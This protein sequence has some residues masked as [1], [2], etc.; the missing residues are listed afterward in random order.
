MVKIYLENKTMCCNSCRIVCS[1]T[2][3]NRCMLVELRVAQMVGSL[4]NHEFESHQ[5]MWIHV[6]EMPVPLIRVLLL[7]IP[8]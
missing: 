7:L 8:C 4:L 2:Y 6:Q 1:Q 3:N 5:Y